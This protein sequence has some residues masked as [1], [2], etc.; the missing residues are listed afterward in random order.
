MPFFQCVKK[1]NVLGNVNI[2]KSISAKAKII[3]I[4]LNSNSAIL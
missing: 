3:K 4:W 1:E 2:W